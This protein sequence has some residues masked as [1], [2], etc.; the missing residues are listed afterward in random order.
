MRRTIASLIGMA[1]AGTVLGA[2]IVGPVT[3]AG[4][5][6]KAW[7]AGKVAS[8]EFSESVY[9]SILKKNLTAPGDGALMIT[10]AVSVE[11]ACSV[12]GIGI[13]AVRL[14]VSGTQVWTSDDMTAEPAVCEGGVDASF[15]Q[16]RGLAE[17]PIPQDTVTVTAVVPVSAGDSVVRVQA[18]ELGGGSYLTSRG[19]SIV[20]LP[21]GSGPLP[22]PG[23]LKP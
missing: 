8:D 21:S 19:L 13:V 9:T 14:N 22:W 12:P 17:P 6:P 23:E 5:T 18:I 2:L 1:F 7:G 20:F 3:A 16:A 10:A 11:D 4:E 15:R